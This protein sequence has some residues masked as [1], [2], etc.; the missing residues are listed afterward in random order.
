M[1]DG[2]IAGLSAAQV[3][4]MTGGGDLAAQYGRAR[5]AVQAAEA[6]QAEE[7]RQAAA[8]EAKRAADFED[9]EKKNAITAPQAMDRARTMSGMATNR[10]VQGALL[11]SEL[12]AQNAAAKVTARI[13]RPCRRTSTLPDPRPPLRPDQA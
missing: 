13:R 5:A 3:G 11:Q 9:F 12:S 7:K 2:A 4:A 8:A 10:M 6:K 1:D